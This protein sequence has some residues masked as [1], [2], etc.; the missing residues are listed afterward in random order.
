MLG[1]FSAF[2]L[3]LLKYRRDILLSLYLYILTQMEYYIKFKS[4]LDG[5]LSLGSISNNE[6]IK[7]HTQYDNP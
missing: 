5:H 2:L 3:E 1:A 6:R 7:N 4:N